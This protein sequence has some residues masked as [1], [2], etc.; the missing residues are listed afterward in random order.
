MSHSLAVSAA[1]S[2]LFLGTFGAF[3]YA[4]PRLRSPKIL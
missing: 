1:C 3:R 2:S 4:V